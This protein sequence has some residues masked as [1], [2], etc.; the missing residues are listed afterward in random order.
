MAMSL[1]KSRD[2]RSSFFSTTGSCFCSGF[3]AE[4][5]LLLFNNVVVVVELG[6]HMRLG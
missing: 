6:F 2:G 4:S 1:D 5:T 3:E